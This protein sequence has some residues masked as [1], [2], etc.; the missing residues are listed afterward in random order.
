MK[1][2]MFFL[3][4]ITF[5]NFNCNVFA[6][7]LNFKNKINYDVQSCENCKD[8]I[9][10]ILKTKS[11]KKYNLDKIE[12]Y[13]FRKVKFTYTLNNQYIEIQI[14]DTK[15]KENNWE[16]TNHKK[17]YNL[18]KSQDSY[19]KK[20]EFKNILTYSFISIWEYDS[21]I[22]SDFFSIV[23]DRYLINMTVKNDKTLKNFKSMELFVRDFIDNCQFNNLK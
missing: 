23:N 20:I 4:V 3:I 7:S 17:S 22:T 1:K 21:E 19:L 2:Y 16:L 8:I 12:C 9:N 14:I 15:N 5:V 10:A 13:P 6:Q 18:I 11:F